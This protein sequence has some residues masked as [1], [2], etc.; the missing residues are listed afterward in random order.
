MKMAGSAVVG[1]FL[2]LLAVTYLVGAFASPSRAVDAT[3]A[4]CRTKGWEDQDLGLSGSQ[5]YNYGLVS[6]ATVTLKA[7]DAHRPKIVRAELR[8]WINMLGWQVVEYKEE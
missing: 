4:E 5:V 8:N 3:L 2:L 1:C 6:T 7:K